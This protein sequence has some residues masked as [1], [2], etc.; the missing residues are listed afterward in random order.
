MYIMVQKLPS[1][2][3]QPSLE[4]NAGVYDKFAG[5]LS[6]DYHNDITNLGVDTKIC[7][8]T[9]HKPTLSSASWN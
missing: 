5:Y 1:T 2:N 9:P 7:L 8:S 3:M 6:C 4:Q